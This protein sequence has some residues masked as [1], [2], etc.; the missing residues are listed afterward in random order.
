MIIAIEGMDGVGKTTIANYISKKY[1]FTFIDK[2]IK[3]IYGKDN[4]II[5]NEL[6]KLLD[7]IY[8]YND[9]I[10]KTWFFGLGNLLCIRNHQNKNIIIDRHYVSNYFWNSD[11]ECKPIYDAMFNIIGKPNLTIIL[12]AE[13]K[14]LLKRIK[15]RNIN[16][17]DLLSIEENGLN[18]MVEFVEKNKINYEIVDT[19]NKSIKDVEKIIDKILEKYL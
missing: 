6:N 4:N 17:P 9:P 16:D 13:Y 18:K 14:E 1:N 5:S 12:H 10:I 15:S 2:P 8:K 7:S 11:E 3:Y 19:T